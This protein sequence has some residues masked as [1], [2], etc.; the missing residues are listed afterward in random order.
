MSMDRPR[1]HSLRHAVIAAAA[2]AALPCALAA[3]TPQSTPPQTPTFRAGVELV[4]V[5]AQVTDRDGMPIDGLQPTDFDVSVS[6]QKR[7]VVSADLIRYSNTTTPIANLPSGPLAPGEVPEGARVFIVAVDLLSFDT[8]DLRPAMKDVQRFVSHLGPEDLV[9][10]YPFPNTPKSIDLTHDHVA[11]IHGLDSLVGLRQK[12]QSSF[13]LSMSEIMDISAGDQ[14]ALQQVIAREC[15]GVVYGSSCTTLIPE[16]ASSLA[17]YYDAQAAMSIYGVDL[18][19]DSLRSVKGRK[20]V[21]FMS[22]GMPNSDRGGRPDV[23]A[24]IHQAGRDIADADTTLYVMH[25]DN[26]IRDSMSAVDEPGLRSSDHLLS[27]GRDSDAMDRGLDLF[28]GAANGLMFDIKAGTSDD[29][30]ARVLRESTAYYL[31]GIEPTD[32]DRDG[33][34]HTIKVKVHA[35]G[36]E[37]RNRTE[38]VIPKK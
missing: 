1:S 27:M 16:E 13:H 22:G 31:L 11:A 10:V 15:T 24:M 37:V 9:A 8:A 21:I 18:L 6:N 14:S 32:A 3:Q 34:H 4:R 2:A 28:A 12:Q 26:T 35:K 17:A 23:T 36:A 20:T 19:L 30:F 33:K 29:Q 25:F 7:H 38:V 5:D